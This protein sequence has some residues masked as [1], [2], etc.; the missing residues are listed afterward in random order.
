MS[1]APSTSPDITEDLPYL[2]SARAA[3]QVAMQNGAKFAVSISGVSFLIAPEGKRSG[4]GTQA[5]TRMSVPISKNQFDTSKE[6]GEQT[7]DGYWIR[8]QVSWHKGAGVKFY[9]PGNDPD[10]Q[11]RFESSLGVDVWTQG[12]LTL[13]KKANLEAALSTGQTAYVASAKSPTT[14]EDLLLYNAN[15]ILKRK[16]SS[17]TTY[18]TTGTT[19]IGQLAVAGS[20][21]LFGYATGIGAV[22]IDGTTA[23][24]LWT[25][26]ATAPRPWWAKGRIIAARLNELHEL[27]LAG[28][29]W[30]T[31]P[32]DLGGRGSLRHP[33]GRL[34]GWSGCY[35]PLQPHRRLQWQ[36]AQAES[37][38]PDRRVPSR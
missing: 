38:V 4:Y 10:T 33:R 21:L 35:L 25:G 24:A 30:P 36:H 31:I 29:T 3:S 14:G 20:K 32:L 7:L 5:Y 8:S 19:P 12:Q 16:G 28:G 15:G 9:E 2:I 6:A 1:F 26:A 37:G 34:L 22:D 17:L 23:A 27:T 13:L 18:T 11:F